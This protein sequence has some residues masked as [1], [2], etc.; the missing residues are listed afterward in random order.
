[1]LFEMIYFRSMFIFIAARTWTSQATLPPWLELPIEFPAYPNHLRNAQAPLGIYLN[2]TYELG[3]AINESFNLA[4]SPW[5]H[6]LHQLQHGKKKE[7]HILALGGTFPYPHGCDVDF[8][9]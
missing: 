7:L 3:L 1:M 2:S 5:Y 9:I 6:A 8:D 4:Q